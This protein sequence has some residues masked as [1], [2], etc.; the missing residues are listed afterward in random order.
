MPFFKTAIKKKFVKKFAKKFAKKTKP[1]TRTTAT[2]GPLRLPDKWTHVSLAEALTKGKANL[3]QAREIRKYLAKQFAWDFDS[4][5]FDKDTRHRLANI[6]ASIW[7]RLFSPS[8]SGTRWKD[9][10]QAKISK[11]ALRNIRHHICPLGFKS[12]KQLGE[13]MMDLHKQIPAKWGPHKIV[14]AGSS[15]MFYSENPK[16]TIPEKNIWHWFDKVKSGDYDLAIS[17]DDPKKVRADLPKPSSAQWGEYWGT[18]KATEALHLRR[19][20]S[21]WGHH[22]FKKFPR[23]KTILD[24]DV[25][26]LI[27]NY[28]YANSGTRCSFWKKDYVWD[29]KTRDFIKPKYGVWYAKP[30]HGGIKGKGKA[31]GKGKGNA[32]GKGKGK[33]KGQVMKK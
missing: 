16:K 8:Q 9:L 17:F 32:K 26:L 3:L 28:D 27:L 6:R 13:M 30:L 24:R 1:Q 11:W 18:T 22:P 19:F 29:S 15:T 14:L 5:F 2:L 4:R 21:K 10:R 7:W 25:G 20:Y 23:A 33:A 31:K 12:R